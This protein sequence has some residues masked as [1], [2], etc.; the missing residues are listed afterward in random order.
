MVVIGV[1]HVAGSISL[2]V[3][4]RESSA[5]CPSC[6]T[7]SSQVHARYRRRPLD[8]P[9]SHYSV[10]LS[11]SVRRF[12]CHNPDCQRKTFAEPF[13]HFLPRYSRRTERVTTL[14]LRLAQA[15]GGE[16]GSRLAA[17]FAIPVSGDTL[18]RL[19]RRYSTPC[20]RRLFAIGVDEFAC[21]RGR[22]YA[23]LIVDLESHRPIDILAD[24][25]K[26]T[27]AGWL[28]SHQEVRVFSR[29]RAEAYANAARLAIPQATQVADRF[30]LAKNASSA[31]DSLLKTRTL[32]LDLGRSEQE[33]SARVAVSSPSASAKEPSPSQRLR[34]E[35]REARLERWA[36][37]HQLAQQEVGIRATARIL[38][39]SRITVR[40]LLVSEAPPQSHV[41][42]PRAGGLS[43]PSLQPY[44]SYLRE[45]WQ[46]GCT[47]VSQ[48]YRELVSQGY[49]GSRSLLLQALKGW[50][51]PRSSPG[52][53]RLE[54]KGSLRWLCLKPPGK[55]KPE[56][57]GLLK[58]LLE[59]DDLLAQGYGLLQ[60]FRQILA[61]RDLV[62]LESW[63]KQ[64]SSSD[65][66]SFMALANGIEADK[67]AVE[68]AFTLPYSNGMLEGHVNRLKLIKRQGY[69]RAG[70][71]LLRARVVAA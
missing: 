8:L 61:E 16:A 68:A 36:R 27:L 11:L 51:E 38:G 4:S 17:C 25:E 26:D 12:R 50:R 30:H 24:K 1:S 66:P 3:A 58:R 53:A 19:L 46:S 20:P 44:L 55:L 13:G 56:E 57:V 71:D 2:E 40:R 60:E 29:D 34:L 39:I 67:A 9:W 43:S 52:Q 48:L 18:L 22:D 28:R 59:S 15:M 54:R 23:T 41:V 6:G 45:S 64:A 32:R 33:P 14:L 70:L 63:L 37:V 69:G 62:G 21:H 47:N 5:R 65:L 49:Q 7:P 35:K 10:R 42:H 31:M